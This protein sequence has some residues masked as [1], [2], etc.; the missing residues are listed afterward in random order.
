M[1]QLVII[2]GKGGTGKTTLAA[3]FCVLASGCV[4]ADCDVDAADMHILLHPETLASSDFYGGKTAVIN[5]SVCVSCG[6][7]VEICRF[8]AISKNFKVDLYSCEGCGF[9]AMVCPVKAVEMKERFSG[10]WF[11]S[12]TPYGPLLHARL[13]P[14]S[15]NSGKLVSKIKKEAIE[16]ATRENK[17]IIIID[18]P[19][20]TGCPLMASL[21]GADLAVIITEPTLSG[22][23]DMKRVFETAVLLKISCAVIVNK[24]D[25]N[26]ENSWE[27]E[28]YCFDNGI[29]LLGRIPFDK[30]AEKAI[31]DMEPLVKNTN[32]PAAKEI[33]KIWNKIQEEFFCGEKGEK[34]G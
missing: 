2:S 34:N 13:E 15:E 8:G 5:P 11:F 18:G 26:A 6:R 27:I 16:T 3:S 9:C 20:G 21:S 12:K 32:S 33:E 28:K 7:C 1:K 29:K 22:I 24:W 31:E 4:I 25:I 23:H 10:K 17:D 30:S 14:G 19:P